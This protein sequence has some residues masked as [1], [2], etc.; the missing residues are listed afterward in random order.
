[1]GTPRP[2]LIAAISLLCVFS[3]R[4]SCGQV[5]AYGSWKGVESYS[6]TDYDQFGNITGGFSTTFDTTL[7]VEFTTSGA[8]VEGGYFPMQLYNVISFGPTSAS[9]SIDFLGLAGFDGNFIVTYNSILPD[10]QI[11]VIGGYADA[12]FTAYLAP[13]GG[14]GYVEEGSFSSGIQAVPEPPALAQ[15]ALGLLLLGAI[16]GARADRARKNR[17]R[18]R[19]AG[20]ALNARLPGSGFAGAGGIRC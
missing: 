13:I 10:G 15:L 11:D 2:T 17:A 14:P 19:S 9:G 6:I 18:E 1:M 16:L 7:G 12:D 20:A 3:P 4:P 5:I 8:F